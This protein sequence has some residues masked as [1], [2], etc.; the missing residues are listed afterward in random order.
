MNHNTPRSGRQLTQLRSRVQRKR[1]WKRYI[2]ARHQASYLVDLRDVPAEPREP[3]SSDHNRHVGTRSPS[4]LARAIVRGYVACAESPRTRTAFA[5]ATLGHRAKTPE[6]TAYLSLMM[7]MDLLEVRPN[8]GRR[9]VLIEPTFARPSFPENPTLP[10]WLKSDEL[11]ARRL[12]TFGWRSVVAMEKGVAFAAEGLQVMRELDP[13]SADQLHGQAQAEVVG[14]Q[15]ALDAAMRH[16]GRKRRARAILKPVSR[17]LRRATQKGTRPKPRVDLMERVLREAYAR[18][19]ARWQRVLER[20]AMYE[21]A[22]A[23]MIYAAE[24]GQHRALV[25]MASALDD[26]APRTLW[27]GSDAAA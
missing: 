25:L 18:N 19:P 24:G 4:D 6:A 3:R 2:G 20:L 9:G 16:P 22:F 8:E 23:A 27:H 13:S 11:D 5:A 14:A 17:A 15:A 7:E 10:P 21:P 12:M 1:G 26:D